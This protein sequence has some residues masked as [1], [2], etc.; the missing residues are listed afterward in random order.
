MT[1]TRFTKADFAQALAELSRLDGDLATVLEQHGP[2]PMWSRKPGFSTLVHIILEQQVSLA[3]AKAAF[4]R[5]VAAVGKLTPESFLELSDTELL[6]IGFSRQ[7]AR[8]CRGLAAEMVAGRLRLDVLGR[9]EQ[10][11]ARE[12]LLSIIGIGPWTADI[13][14]LMALKKPDIWPHGDL[15]LAEA[16]REIKSL[17]S[18]PDAEEQLAIA[19]QWRPWRAVAAR[20]HWHHYLST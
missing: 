7:K 11:R 13:Y 18:R 8:Y 14:L 10:E 17:E 12:D 16:M 3:S 15:A 2:P 19:E 1:S 4:D 6:R 9:K 20:I 5:L